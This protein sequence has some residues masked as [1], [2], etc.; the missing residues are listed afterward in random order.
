M[1]IP[2]TAEPA[3]SQDILDI[4]DFLAMMRLAAE[5]LVRDEAELTALDRA[6]GDGDHGQNMRIGFRAVCEQLDTFQ[7]EELDIGDHLCRVGLIL[8][9]AIGGASGPLY[10]AA[11]VEAGLTV[12]GRRE[13]GLTELTEALQAAGRSVARR[14]H[15]YPG[16]KTLL[17]T[18][19]PAADALRTALA[20]GASLRTALSQM[21]EAARQGML[22]TTPLVARCGLAMR[23][24][25]RSVGHQD[26]GATSC[27][28]L[29][30]ALVSAWEARRE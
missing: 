6:I 13:V 7:T 26:P 19:Q 16:D 22:S 11:F 23:L 29:L 9:S 2:P 15:C 25:P 21:R 20:G 5:W 28:L 30:S 18:L 3:T 4:D 17:D 10:S 27:Y 8:L 1:A 14:G 12:S 24:G